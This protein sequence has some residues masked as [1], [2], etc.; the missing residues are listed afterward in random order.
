[1]CSKGSV[2]RSRDRLRI[3]A[4]L[5]DAMTGAHLW[6][7]K[8]DGKLDDVFEFQDQITLKVASVAE[9]TI[10]WAEI[11]RSR[12]ERP[13]QRPRPMTSTCAPCRCTCRRPAMPMAKRSRCC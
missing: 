1:M 3:T 4:Q 7:D 11:E 6:A 10:R 8:F 12:R 9:P 13:G 2:R 5:V